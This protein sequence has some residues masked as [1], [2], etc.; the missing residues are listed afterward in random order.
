[1]RIAQS[2]LV[3]EVQDTDASVEAVVR[4]IQHMETLKS[5]GLKC[6]KDVHPLPAFAAHHRDYLQRRLRHVVKRHV[7]IVSVISAT[8]VR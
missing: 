2:Q 7:E 4:G 3:A 5:E 8:Q 1:M 6:A